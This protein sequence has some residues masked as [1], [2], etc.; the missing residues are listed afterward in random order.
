MFCNALLNPFFGSMIITSF[1]VLL[2]S[3]SIGRKCE[4]LTAKA[5]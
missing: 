3:K 2:A 5:I 4:S 1:P